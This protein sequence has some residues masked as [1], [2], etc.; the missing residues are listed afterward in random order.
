MSL[1]PFQWLRSQ[2][3][4]SSNIAISSSDSSVSSALFLD[5]RALANS[6]CFKV[7]AVGRNDMSER[8]R[9]FSIASPITLLSLLS[10]RVLTTKLFACELVQ[11][12][13]SLPQAAKFN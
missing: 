13:S 5:R 11:S 9:D 8:A 10:F 2:V 4:R 7:E 3:L 12:R 1:F 6:D